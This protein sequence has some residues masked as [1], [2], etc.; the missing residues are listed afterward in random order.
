M[1]T[2]LRRGLARTPL[3]LAW[4]G[5]STVVLV[6]TYAVDP[7]LFGFAAMA[8]AWVGV[9]FAILTASLA[10]RALPWSLLAAAPALIALGVLSNFRWA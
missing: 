9:A 1:I 2:G 4:M 5:G 7:Y 10:L 8:C 6:A 3:H